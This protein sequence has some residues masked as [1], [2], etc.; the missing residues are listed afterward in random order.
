METL[1]KFLSRVSR[2]NHKDTHSQVDLVSPIK[3]KERILGTKVVLEKYH[4]VVVEKKTIVMVAV[5]VRRN[6]TKGS[7]GIP[8]PIEK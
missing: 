6:Q 5:V 8:K 3:K 2:R 7:L 1:R 4:L